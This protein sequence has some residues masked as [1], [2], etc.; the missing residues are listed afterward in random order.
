[1]TTLPVASVPAQATPVICAT[2]GAVAASDPPPLTW[3]AGIERGRRLW[4]CE[5]CMRENIR[6]IEGKLDSAWW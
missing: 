1:L 5:R 2:C 6:S 4:A 3:S